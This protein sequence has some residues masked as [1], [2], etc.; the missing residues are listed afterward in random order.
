MTGGAVCGELATLALS[1]VDAGLLLALAGI[2]VAAGAAAVITT[3]VRIRRP[4]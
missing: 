3:R 4:N 1:G 2:L